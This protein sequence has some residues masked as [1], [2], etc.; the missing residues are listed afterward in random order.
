MKISHK[1]L[2]LIAMQF[3]D[4]LRNFV[5]QAQCQTPK[6][7]GG[8]LN[9]T[10]RSSWTYLTPLRSALKSLRKLTHEVIELTTHKAVRKQLN[11]LKKQ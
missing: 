9:L 8:H 5:K 10:K 1:H 2:Y 7:V 4:L 6:E 11:I 3:V